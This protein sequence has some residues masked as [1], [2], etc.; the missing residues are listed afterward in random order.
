M[1]SKSIALF[2]RH[3]QQ[4]TTRPPPPP[5]DP[6]AELER[7]KNHYLMKASRHFAKAQDLDAQIALLRGKHQ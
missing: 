6:I 7:R 3:Q 1:S 2:E 5:D 4:G